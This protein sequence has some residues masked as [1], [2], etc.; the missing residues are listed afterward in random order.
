MSEVYTKRDLC[1]V[2]HSKD[3][4]LVMSYGDMP[5]AGGFVRSGDPRSSMKFPLDLL[6]CNNCTLMQT[7]QDVNP[8]LLFSQYS[9]VSG[10]SPSLRHHF[11]LLASTLTNRFKNEGLYIDIGCNDGTLI[12]YMREFGVERVLGIDPSDI[13][14]QNSQY[15]KWNLVNDYLNANTADR[16]ISEYGKA[17]LITACNVLAHNTNPHDI[18]EGI[19][20][21]LDDNG[22][23]VIEVHYQGSL[24]QKS[25]FDTVYH[26]HTCY[27]SVV[28]LEHLLDDHDL[29]IDNIIPIVNHGGSIRLFVSHKNSHIYNSFDNSLQ[30]L[31]SIEKNYTWTHF[32]SNAHRIRN[33]IESVIYDIKQQSKSIWAYGASGRATIFLNWCH[34]RQNDI[35]CVLDA[36]SSR[37]GNVVPGVDIPIKPSY[38][39]K[40][41]Q[42]DTLFITAW[43]YAD[44]IIQQHPE[45]HGKWF[46]ALPEVR[47]L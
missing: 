41:I 2:C 15:H 18:V 44:S 35:D 27:Y 13:A 45:Y 21:L 33:V 7:G 29:K 36:S 16:I 25:Q 17:Y 39:L 23:A 28:S 43:N 24:L 47:Y 9:Y 30:V 1:R 11:K 6:R 34:L 38:L 42:P 8:D 4:S 31:M 14:L 37:Y 12:G 20:K 10:H 32:A 46:V 40:T 26:E 19:S 5:L 3:L 22:I